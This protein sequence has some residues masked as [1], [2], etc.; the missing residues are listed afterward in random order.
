MTGLDSFSSFFYLSVSLFP[1]SRSPPFHCSALPPVENLLLETSIST[2]RVE[3]AKLQTLEGN[4]VSIDNHDLVHL[5]LPNL[6]RITG[7]LK[8]EVLHTLYMG[9]S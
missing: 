7:A 4:I 6:T 9:C 3:L 8:I 5:L 2:G 1:A